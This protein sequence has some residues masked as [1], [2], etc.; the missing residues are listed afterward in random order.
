M[1]YNERKFHAKLTKTLVS[2]AKHYPFRVGDS[3]NQDQHAKDAATWALRIFNES[4][5]AAKTQKF[6]Q[7][8]PHDP[9]SDFDDEDP[10]II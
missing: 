10:T 1:S 7:V 9:N 3:Y 2:I 4:Q 6:V 5:K 8:F